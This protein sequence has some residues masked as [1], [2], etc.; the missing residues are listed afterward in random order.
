VLF[1]S[2]EAPKELVLTARHAPHEEKS[3]WDQNHLAIIAIHADPDAPW[4]SEVLWLRQPDWARPL[5]YTQIVAADVDGDGKTDL[6]GMDWNTIGHYPGEWERLGDAHAFR[7]SSE[8]ADVWVRSLPT[9]WANKGIAV[10]DFDDDGEAEV[11]ANGPSG[12]RD[13]FWRLSAS[14]GEKEGFLALSGWSVQRGPVLADIDG[15]GSTEVLAAVESVVQGKVGA[16]VVVDVNVP[17]EPIG[18]Q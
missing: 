2:G 13:G 10:A 5:S 6:F 1:R 11:L 4:R 17:F 12:G 9:W 3:T 16:V 18:E 15:D 14:S 7:L 8:G